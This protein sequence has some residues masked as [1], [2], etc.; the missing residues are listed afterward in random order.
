[1]KKV[2]SKIKN[3]KFKKNFSVIEPVNLYDCS[4][5]KDVFVGPFVEI[6]KGV[7]I[8][9]NTRVS[10]HSFICEKVKIG[11]NCFIGHGV[12]FVNDKFSNGKRAHGD[13]KKW[14]PTI[15]DDNVLIGSNSTILPVKVISG[16]VIGAGSVVTKDIIKKGVYAGNPA[17]LIKKL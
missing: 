12:M 4:F 15:I 13:K 9:D 2:R 3:I 10:S 8:N 14:L 17:K 5:G 16:C 6:Q 1:M 11:K 7:I